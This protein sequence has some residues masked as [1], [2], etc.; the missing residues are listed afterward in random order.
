M[1]TFI[2]LRIASAMNPDNEFID[3][4]ESHALDRLCGQLRELSAVNGSHVDVS[5]LTSSEMQDDW[6]AMQLERVSQAGVYRWFVPESLGGMGWSGRNIVSGYIQLAAACLTTTFIVTQRVAAIARI[7]SSGNETLR[8]QLIPGLLTGDQPATVGISHLTTSRQHVREPALRAVATDSGFTINGY[9][10]WVTGASGAAHIVMGAELNDCRQILFV[11]P[12]DAPGVTIEPG[13]D[14]VA[15]SGSRTGPIKCVDVSLDQ[16]T[17]LAGPVE[18][19]LSRSSVASTGSFQ[20]SA[21]AM[22]LTQSAIDFI[23][24]ESHQRS[25]LKSNLM[26]LEDQQASIQDR[27][28]RLAAGLPIC[29]TEELRAN[30]NS[31]VLR[32]TQSA[33]VAAKGAG[34]VK[35]HPVGRWCQEALFFLV[36]SCPQAVLDANLCEFAGIEG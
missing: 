36:W 8:D 33:M 23:R 32:A 25:D 29:S 4:P 9:S 16:G 1:K 19:V 3:S 12:V 35:G 13:F 5:G 28:Y 31:L 20:S 10:P 7:C 27:L 34:F 14:L 21:L 30:A 17:V 6:P 26:A 2:E 24:N 11:V 22:G 18:S 15:L